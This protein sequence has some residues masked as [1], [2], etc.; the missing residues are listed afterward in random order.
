MEPGQIPAVLAMSWGKGDPQIDAIALVFMDDAG[1]LREHLKLDNLSDKDCIKEFEELL[2]RRSPDVIVVGGFSIHTSKLYAKIKEYLAGPSNEDQGS[3]TNGSGA[4]KI[5]T[6]NGD[7]GQDSLSLASFGTKKRDIPV[8]YVHDHSA[9][10]YQHS[11]RAAEELSALSQ[12]ARYCV[13]LAR[14]TQSPL[15]E[16]AAL[17]RD[18]AAITF[19]EDNQQLVSSLPT[20]GIW[21]TKFIFF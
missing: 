21:M 14:Y 16:Y 19:D 4:G 8:I 20:I 6:G 1:R 7:T 18:I 15:N 2:E 3:I 11:R 10:I 5:T 13:G 12:T 17:G 9:R